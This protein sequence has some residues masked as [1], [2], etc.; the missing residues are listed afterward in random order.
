[1]A[2][3]FWAPLDAVLDPEATRDADIFVRGLRMRRPA[4]HYGERVIWG[5]TERILHNLR[6]LI[7]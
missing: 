2:D 4:I 3:L 7:A 5:M 1:M 6:E